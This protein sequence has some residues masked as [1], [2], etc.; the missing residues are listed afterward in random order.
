MIIGKAI[1]WTFMAPVYGAYIIGADIIVPILSP[2]I[3]WTWGLFTG[4]REEPH[5]ARFADKKILKEGGFFNPGGFLCGLHKC[6]KVFTDP[7]RSVIS[8]GQPGLGKT[9]MCIADILARQDKPHILALDPAGDI[10]QGTLQALVERGYEVITVDFSDPM[11]SGRYDPFGEIDQANE[12]AF[13][14]DVKAI[15]ALLTP[16]GAKEN[17]A[18]VHFRESAKN[19]LRSMVVWRLLKKEGA[20]LGE[21]VDR[22][23]VEKKARLKEFDDMRKSSNRLVRQGVETFEAAGDKERGSMD[24]TLG[25]MLEA[26]L[27]NTVTVISR[28]GNWSFKQKLQQEKPVAIFIKM[29]LMGKETGGAFSRLMVGNCCNAIRSMFDEG[30]TSKNGLMVYL[31]EPYLLGNCQPIVDCVIELRKAKARVVANFPSYSSVFETFTDAQRFIDNCAWVISGSSN[32]ITLYKA[33]VELAGKRLVTN[34][35]VSKGD[36]ETETKSEHWENLLS[37]GECQALK[38]E[39]VMVIS[40][41][42]LW[43][44]KKAF[45]IKKGVRRFL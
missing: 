14:R 28:G 6:L 5:V 20:S 25:R 12:F 15:C 8:F 37:I 29:G 10:K 33:A 16:P 38:P 42:L 43:K 17:D 40:R 30:K 39:E 1:W 35:S 44:G 34:T 23:L 18:G 7:E 31:D 3:K 26:Y 11:N 45:E 19:M 9:S 24:S 36:R 32:D 2:I 13:T 21:I 41:G 4:G 22:L 27:D